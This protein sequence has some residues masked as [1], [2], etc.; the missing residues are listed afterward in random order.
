M[1]RPFGTF[2]FSVNAGSGTYGGAI[3]KLP[4]RSRRTGTSGGASAG[5]AQGAAWATARTIAAGRVEPDPGPADTEAEL[6][7]TT[8]VPAKADASRMRLIVTPC[9]DLIVGLTLA[10][11][12]GCRESLPW[13]PTNKRLSIH[14]LCPS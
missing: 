6:A 11:P 13:L 12:K 5:R 14:T 7:K 8:S 4:S 3:R 9:L 2:G 10:A 1:T